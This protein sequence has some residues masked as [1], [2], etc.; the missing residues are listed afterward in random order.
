MARSY[1]IRL[2]LS[3][4][5]GWNEAVF[6]ETMDACAAKG[7][8]TVL[9]DVVQTEFLSHPE[10]TGESTMCKPKAQEII[11]RIRERGIK[12]IPEVNFSTAHWLWMKDW[13]YRICS[14]EYYT[15]CKDIITEAAEL[16]GGP[17]IIHLGLDEESYFEVRSWDYF[18]LRAGKQKW[19]DYNFYMDCCRQAG[20]RPAA[21]ADIYW[22]DPVNCVKN[23]SKDMILY[24]WYYGAIHRENFR[25][26][27]QWEAWIR[28]NLPTSIP[29]NLAYW[30]N[31]ARLELQR[32][33]LSECAAA[34][35]DVVPCVST[36][37]GCDYN[38]PEVLEWCQSQCDP[39][40]VKGYITAPWIGVT[41]ATRPT[42]LKS[43][44][45]LQDARARFCPEDC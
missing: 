29:N 18:V 36:F 6:E 1:S 8:D 21:W 23:V 12:I 33:S 13:K 17:E 22:L 16:C 19:H 44:A 42:L 31:E 37:Y 41:E 40:R 4:G 7:I 3:G 30:R 32:R 34:G 14:P 39:E 45:L 25:T 10:L 27:D 38:T 28:E 26:L 35:Y 15:F 2:G 20:A 5:S 24:P 9:L 43:I 11:R